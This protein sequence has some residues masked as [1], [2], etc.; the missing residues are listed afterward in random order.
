MVGRSV[1]ANAR[2]MRSTRY[3][4]GRPPSNHYR[5]VAGLGARDG[6]S[7]WR[8]GTTLRPGEPHGSWTRRDNVE[9]GARR[10]CRRVHRRLPDWRSTG[11]ASFENR[12]L[13]YDGVAVA[14]GRGLAKPSGG[15]DWARGSGRDWE[16]GRAYARGFRRARG[17]ERRV[18]KWCAV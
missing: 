5:L 2:G 17:G 10:R 6:R 12:L 4:L 8:L 15:D 18:R 3:E 13:K 16:E 7:R 1:P 9:F 14:S 11:N